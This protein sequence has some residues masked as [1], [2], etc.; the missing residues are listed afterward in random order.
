M[1]LEI[2]TKA[3][4]FELTAHDGSRWELDS[5]TGRV[6]VLLF[7]PQNETLVCTKQ[8]CSVRDNW[9]EYLATNAEIVGISPSTPDENLAFAQKRRLPIPILADPGRVTTSEFAKHW[10]LPTSLTRGIVV[11]D[12]HGIIRTS[13]VMLRAFRPSDADVVRAI[14]EA[15]GDL[16]ESKYKDIRSRLKRTKL[17]REF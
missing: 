10:L 12:A 3:P 13:R 1:A 5:H 8:L 11:F 4:N 14:Y 16:L 7:Y 15:R 6:R 2:G 9:Q 17:S